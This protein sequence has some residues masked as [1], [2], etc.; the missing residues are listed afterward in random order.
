MC[1]I[2]LLFFSVLERWGKNVVNTSTNTIS[3]VLTII[4][5]VFLIISSDFIFELVEGTFSSINSAMNSTPS[6]LYTDLLTTLE[7]D[8]VLMTS[9]AEDGLDMFGLVSGNITY[10]VGYLLV[11]ILVGICKIA[12][13]S[14]IC[15]YLLTRVFFLEIMKFLF[16]IAVAL[17]TIKQT[18]G[19]ISKWLRLYIGVS[20]LGLIYIGILK[21]CDI[22]QEQLQ[23]SF[24]NY[25]PDFFGSFMNLNISIWAALITIIIVF[26]LKVTLFNKATSYVISFFS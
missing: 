15:G 6:T 7:L 2:L 23:A 17:S 11:L 4:G 8:Y 25:S 3:D 22:T 21:I 5:Y 24:T 14:M 1:A 12:E 20:L 13:M 19:L 9:S 18:S 16:P 26:T 10:F